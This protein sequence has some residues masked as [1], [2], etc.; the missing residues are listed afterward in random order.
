MNNLAEYY[1]A[2]LVHI[3][4]Q[5]PGGISQ[6]RDK[7]RDTLQ[8]YTKIPVSE[9]EVREAL[10]IL[11]RCDV[12]YTEEDEFAGA[13]VVVTADRFNAFLDNVSKER[14][15]YDAIVRDAHDDHVGINRAENTHLP[16]LEAYG[17]YTVLRKYSAFGEEWLDTALEEIRRRAAAG[18]LQ[19]SASDKVIQLKQ[20][21]EMLVA[22]RAAAEELRTHLLRGNDLGALSQE[23]ARAAAGEIEQLQ[24]SLAKDV[25]RPAE[26]KSRAR[27]TLKWIGEKAAGTFVGQ[28]ATALFKLIMNLLG[29]PT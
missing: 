20:D 21:D 25:V 19:T 3:A 6:H 5:L 14:E 4:R 28:A 17:K 22:I 18:D 8:G 9:D 16:Y 10:R 12:S 24:A 26:L 2:A 1:A 15:Q 23:Q 29:I 13:F 7:L 11:N 27:D